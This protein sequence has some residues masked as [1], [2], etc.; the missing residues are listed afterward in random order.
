VRSI[1]HTRVALVGAGIAA[2]ALVSLAAAQ[3]G[4][5]LSWYTVDGGGARSSGGG[6][7]LE[8]SVGQPDAGT[9]SGGGYTLQGGFWITDITQT[10]TPTTT[11][12]VTST[13]IPTAAVTSTSTLAPTAT[14]TPTAT[15]PAATLTPT[16]TPPPPPVS[17][18]V[19]KAGPDR[20]QVTVTSTGTI[21]RILWIPDPAFDLEF[22]NG[23]PLQGGVLIL[24]PPGSR[25]VFYV[26]RVS[27]TSVTVPLTIIGSFGTWQTFVG[28]GPDTW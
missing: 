14:L 12:T 19:V 24:K 27:G 17:L 16:V 10:P 21:D 3:G 8:G 26:R 2:L 22:P 13:P 15:T 7:T 4:F 23:G 25:V 9:L 5:D 20:L 28:G 11:A 1:T 18:T 6:F